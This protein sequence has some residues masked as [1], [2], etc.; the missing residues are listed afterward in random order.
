MIR[1][2]I[3]RYPGWLAKFFIVFGVIL[4]LLGLVQLVMAIVEGFDI[5][6]MSGDWG[7]VFFTF[8]GILFI[9]LGTCGHINRKY[10]IEWDDLELRFLLPGKKGAGS[11]KFEDILSVQVRLFEIRIQIPGGV[12]IFDLSNLQHEDLRKVK[13]KFRALAKNDHIQHIADKGSKT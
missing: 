11:I 3:L 5:V 10:Y 9:I 7:S 4:V 13:E 12:R 1:I 8:Q 2:Y 6:F